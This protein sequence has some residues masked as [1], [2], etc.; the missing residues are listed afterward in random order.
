M[1]LCIPCVL[2]EKLF[3]SSSFRLLESATYLGLGAR[4]SVFGGKQTTKGQAGNKGADQP[5]HPR[6]LIST[7]V[8][9]LMESIVSKLAT[10]E[11]SN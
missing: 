7:F 3:N 6:R 4:K 9:Q 10:G 1:I 5:A 11:F 8:I 2:V